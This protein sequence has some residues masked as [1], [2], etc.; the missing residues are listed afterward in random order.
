MTSGFVVDRGQKP[1]EYFVSFKVFAT[2]KYG[3]TAVGTAETGF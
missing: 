2:M 1:Q 3:K